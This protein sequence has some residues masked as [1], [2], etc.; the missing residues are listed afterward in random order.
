MITR[1]FN[2][3]IGYFDNWRLY[4]GIKIGP[5]YRNNNPYV[6]YGGEAGINYQICEN[7][8]IG[9]KTDV[10]YRDDLMSWGG[11]GKFVGSGYITITF[12]L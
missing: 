2:L 9:L 5:V 10:I 3:K 11:K 1:G 7:T 4:S 6:N 12:K 8:L